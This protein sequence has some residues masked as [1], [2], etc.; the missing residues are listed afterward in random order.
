[1]F[2][3]NRSKTVAASVIKNIWMT[4]CQPGDLTM[5]KQKGYQIS[6]KPRGMEFET[7]TCSETGIL[8]CF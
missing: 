3:N 5:I 8:D 1:M 4:Q 6:P 7:V 2:N